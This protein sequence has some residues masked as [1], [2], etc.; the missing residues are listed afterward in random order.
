ML[1]E[2]LLER[3]KKEGRQIKSTF[4]REGEMISVSSPYVLEP[5]QFEGRI[6]LKKEGIILDVTFHPYCCL[7]GG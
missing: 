4:I 3:S 5:L 6:K 1:L 2:S 7:Y